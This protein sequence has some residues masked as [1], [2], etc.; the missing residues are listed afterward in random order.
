MNKDIHI[1]CNGKIILKGERD[2]SSSLWLVPI[3]WAENSFNQNHT[4]QNKS[5]QSLTEVVLESSSTQK[6]LAWLLYAACGYPVKSARGKAIA[7]GKFATFPDLIKN[8][9]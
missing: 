6:E 5:N 8:L 4:S 3:G 7:N 1:S 2:P 9:V